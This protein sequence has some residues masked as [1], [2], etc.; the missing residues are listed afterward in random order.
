MASRLKEQV[1]RKQKQS[2]LQQELELVIQ[3][4]ARQQE[5]AIQQQELA[6]QQQ[7]EE[8]ERKQQELARQ[9]TQT[10]LQQEQAIQQR[11]QQAREDI[12][13]KRAAQTGAINKFKESLPA[14]QP[15]SASTKFAQLMAK[16][17]AEAQ[18]QAVRPTQQRQA[19]ATGPLQ[20][21]QVPAVR[22]VS[23]VSKQIQQVFLQPEERSV[24]SIAP[25]LQVRA[26]ISRFLYKEPSEPVLFRRKVLGENV[27]R[28]LSGIGDEE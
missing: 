22:P 13:S 11:E 26:D 23:E 6:I 24:S 7:Q 27:L 2:R 9:Q 18:A 15:S 8:L 25:P 12:G 21:R 17:N 5:L 14:V 4:E 1:K 3:H 20:Q 19:P 16:R 10:R 28:A